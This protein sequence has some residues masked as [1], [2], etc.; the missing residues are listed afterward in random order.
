MNAR[1]MMLAVL[2][3]G[4]LL[5]LLAGVA[6][7][8]TMKPAPEPYWR[9]LR[10]IDVPSNVSPWQFV[11]AG[12]QDLSPRWDEDR[13]PTWKRR[14]L[15]RATAAATYVPLSNAVYEPETEP[16]FDAPY[17]T[18]EPAYHEPVETVGRPDAA[19]GQDALPD[20]AAAMS[21]RDAATALAPPDPV[22]DE[23]EPETVVVAVPA[24]L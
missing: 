22:L 4:P 11:D 16:A 13:M 3:G 24:G 23:E 21:A 15:E 6:I 12:A 7:D 2:G 8:P 14:A 5:G 18:R 10:P 20:R 19:A 1:T 9:R 17:D